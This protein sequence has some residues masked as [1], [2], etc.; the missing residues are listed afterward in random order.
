MMKLLKEELDLIIKHKDLI[1]SVDPSTTGKFS[2]IDDYIWSSS[3][4]DS[5]YAWIQS[6]S[7]GNQNNS[8]KN[9]DYWVVP[10]MRINS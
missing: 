4:S 8:N 2:D 6:P 3:E 10:F 9:H 7:D 1:D 5:Y